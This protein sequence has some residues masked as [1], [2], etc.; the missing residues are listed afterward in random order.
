MLNNIQ[1]IQLDLLSTQKFLN[2]TSPAS[3]VTT[4]YI[5]QLKP[6]QTIALMKLDVADISSHREMAKVDIGY[7]YIADRNS[8]IYM[9][10]CTYIGQFPRYWPFAY[11]QGVSQ[12]RKIVYKFTTSS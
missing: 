1:Q 11:I 6:L 10:T 5:S 9:Y 7:M 12:S 2:L 4:H 3:H 8:L